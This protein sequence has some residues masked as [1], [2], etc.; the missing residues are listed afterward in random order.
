MRNK[1]P[2][3]YSLNN[4]SSNKKCLKEGKIKAGVQWIR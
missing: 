2:T 1:Q 4:L 3:A